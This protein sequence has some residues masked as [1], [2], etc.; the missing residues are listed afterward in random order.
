MGY[1]LTMCGV[2]RVSDSAFIPQD[3]TN[4]DWLEYQDW[5]LSGGQVLPLNES[6]EKAAPD[7]SVKTLAKKWLAGISAQP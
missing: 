6:L 3:P 5:L 7:S 1:Q 4:R 2:L